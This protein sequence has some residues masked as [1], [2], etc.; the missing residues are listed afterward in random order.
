[1]S[2]APPIF[3]NDKTFASH[4]ESSIK[5]TACFDIY[6]GQIPRS[7]TVA[8]KDVKNPKNEYHDW[9]AE[10]KSEQPFE[11]IRNQWVAETI[12][13]NEHIMPFVRTSPY[14]PYDKLSPEALS[15]VNMIVGYRN[16]L[17]KHIMAK[18]EPVVNSAYNELMTLK[19]LDDKI[20]NMLGIL[21]LAPKSDYVKSMKHYNLTDIMKE[22]KEEFSIF[23]SINFPGSIYLPN[24][25]EEEKSV[26]INIV[27]K[28]EDMGKQ[29]SHVI[30]LSDDLI[31]RHLVS[32]E[33]KDKDVKIMTKA[34]IKKLEIRIFI[35]IFVSMRRMAEKLLEAIYKKTDVLN[36]LSPL[37]RFN[38]AYHVLAKGKDVYVKSLADP[39]VCLYMMDKFQP[40]FEWMKEATKTP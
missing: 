10:K 2:I 40:L 3:R 7:R 29:Y 5:T 25:A 15:A 38:F 22:I 13:S 1:M 34:D 36:K 24:I 27:E 35:N 37:D 17:I 33:W 8:E 21:G 20:T 19:K 18:P 26:P 28:P 4:G 39:D 11:S 23:K 12:A 6:Y 14:I 30:E 32:L 16:S 31:F 9:L